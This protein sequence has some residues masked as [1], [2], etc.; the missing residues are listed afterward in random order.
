MQLFKNCVGLLIDKMMDEKLIE[1]VGKA[2]GS[3]YVLKA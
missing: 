1:K 2:R 3:K